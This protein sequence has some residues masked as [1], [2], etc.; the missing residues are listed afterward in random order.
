MLGPSLEL[1]TYIDA[2][3]PSPYLQHQSL[4]TTVETECISMKE[5]RM[6]GFEFFK[7]AMVRA[8][9]IAK[10][11]RLHTTRI[12]L[13]L[14]PGAQLLIR[15]LFTSFPRLPSYFVPVR[16]CSYARHLLT[17]VFLANLTITI[18]VKFFIHLLK[19]WTNGQS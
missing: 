4:T 7:R 3:Q 5:P 9:R 1:D 12:V 17:W 10:Q 19:I 2:T 11:K 15:F 8:P 13:R 6:N 16:W 14:I 18:F